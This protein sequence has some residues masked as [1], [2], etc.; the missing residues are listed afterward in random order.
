MIGPHTERSMLLRSTRTDP[1]SLWLPTPSPTG[2]SRRSPHPPTMR[3][4]VGFAS[5]IASSPRVLFLFACPILRR[6]S[7]GTQKGRNDQSTIRSP[8]PT[9]P[10][11]VRRAAR[12]ALIVDGPRANAISACKAVLRSIRTDHG[13]LWLP[14]AI[15]PA[16]TARCGSGRGEAWFRPCTPA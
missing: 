8:L 13:S 1:G 14:T 5:H 16:R 15:P 4:L 11:P 6:C 12:A 7:G 2:P 9:G 10:A 3:P